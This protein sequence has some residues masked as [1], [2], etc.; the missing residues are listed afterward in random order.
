MGGKRLNLHQCVNQHA[1]KVS[2]E[3]MLSQ[4]GTRSVPTSAEKLS[5]SNKYKETFAKLVNQ[6]EFEAEKHYYP[7]VL[8]AHIHP[9]VAS[10]FS[11]GNIRILARFTH[12]NPQVNSSTL[13]SLLNYSPKYFHWAGNYLFNKDLICSMLLLQM[14]NDK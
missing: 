1:T 7:R 2:F 4:E 12:L 5:I 14:V 8:N 9:L 10:F 3:F 13:E 6:G 11:L